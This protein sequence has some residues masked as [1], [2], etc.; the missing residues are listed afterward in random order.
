MDMALEEARAAGEPRRGAGWLRR[1]CAA[2]RFWRGPVTAP[3]PTAIR[4][5]MPKSRHPSCGGRARLRA[6]RRLRPLCHARACAMCAGA[7]AFARIRRLYYGAADPKGGAV[8]NGVKF[9]PHRPA[10]T[11]RR[12]MAAWRKRRRRAAQR[13][14]RANGVDVK[15][16]AAELSSTP[17]SPRR[18][19][20]RWRSPDRNRA[21]ERSRRSAGS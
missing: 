13:F 14:L 17:P 6:A 15:R 8:D 4:R 1:S 3:S 9:L 19:S 21:C 20:A 7:V 10:I 18:R 11:G 5:R 12:S 16:A 2:A